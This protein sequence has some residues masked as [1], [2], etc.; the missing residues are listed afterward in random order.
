[1]RTETTCRHYHHVTVELD[2]A[3]RFT[4]NARWLG[5]KPLVVT[6]VSA[7]FPSGDPLAAFDQEKVAL[8][9][10]Y[11]KTD[12]TPSAIRPAFPPYVRASTLPEVIRETIRTALWDGEHRG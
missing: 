4:V 11:A 8:G 10:F 12:G 1:M 9:G 5:G 7:E 2:E 6:R 3:E